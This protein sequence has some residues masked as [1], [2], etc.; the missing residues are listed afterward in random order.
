M[1]LTYCDGTVVHKHSNDPI[2]RIRHCTNHRFKSRA[3]VLE[4]GLL[5]GRSEL[6]LG[7]VVGKSSTVTHV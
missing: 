4:V 1:L 5:E 7:F 2:Q 3:G 6:A